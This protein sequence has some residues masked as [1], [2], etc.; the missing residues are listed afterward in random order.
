MFLINLY[1]LKKKFVERFYGVD[2]DQGP[3]DKRIHLSGVRDMPTGYYNTLAV[4][5]VKKQSGKATR[6]KRQREPYSSQE[7]GTAVGSIKC[8]RRKW[9][10][11]QQTDRQTKPS[12]AKARRHVSESKDH[13]VWMVFI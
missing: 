11:R 3:R 12:F 6:S 2:M 4:S 5:A 10:F 13:W 7:L 1:V 9:I 8:R